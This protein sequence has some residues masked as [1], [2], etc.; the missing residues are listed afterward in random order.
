MT[1]TA[2]ESEQACAEG[3]GLFEVFG[4]ARRPDG[5]LEIEKD[6][7]ADIFESDEAAV[8]FVRA[9]AEKGSALHRYALKLHEGVL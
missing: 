7:E 1:L 8:A 2:R 6:D 3:W 4:S 9:Q 5:S